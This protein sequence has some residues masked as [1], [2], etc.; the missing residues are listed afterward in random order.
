METP[1]EA[2]FV[3]HTN[4]SQACIELGASNVTFKVLSR[5]EVLLVPQLVL[6]PDDSIFEGFRL[7]RF[8]P[9]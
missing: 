7:P 8:F 1:S 2:E 6:R 4:H 3:P 5:I 9:L